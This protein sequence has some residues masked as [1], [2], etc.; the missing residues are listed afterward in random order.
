M[1]RAACLLIPLLAISDTPPDLLPLQTL[2]RSLHIQILWRDLTFPVPTT[3]GPIEGRPADPETL[4]PYARL[5]IPEW[6]LY[7]PQLLARARLKRIILCTDLAFAGQKRNA[8]P[9]FEHDTL[10]LEVARG[11]HSPD[12]L[13]AVIHHDFFHM[14]DYRDDGR[15]DQDEPWTRLNPPGFRYGDGGHNAQDLASTSL[16]TDRYP[17]FLNHYGTTALEEDKAELYA[18]LI[19]QPR[20]V[21]RRARQDPFLHA[22]IR[23]LKRLLADFCPQINDSFWNQRLARDQPQPPQ[24]LP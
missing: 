9:D 11:N 16:L 20:E 17:G 5:F 15:L 12:Y 18:H 13:R 14:I 21:D 19:V 24:N 22:K 1:K 10:Y 4:A 2:A 23:R 3:Y 6:A 8:V 7:P